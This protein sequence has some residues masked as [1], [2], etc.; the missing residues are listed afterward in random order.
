M[1]NYVGVKFLI[2]IS[3]MVLVMFILAFSLINKS[4]ENKKY[5]HYL[6]SHL[7]MNIS[8][9]VTRV[10]NSD[11]SLNEAITNRSISV[12]KLSFLSANLL[13]ISH[14]INTLNKLAKVVK[15]EDP[16]HL[17]N[18]AAVDH[19][20]YINSQ[21]LHLPIYE[22]N[23]QQNDKLLKLNDDNIEKLKQIQEDVSS[24]KQVIYKALEISEAPL[25]EEYIQKHSSDFIVKK[26]WIRLYREL[27]NLSYS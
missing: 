15:D 20:M 9:L 22:L 10:S 3:V 11:R 26:D 5:Q 19:H 4:N 16:N 25:S 8:D 12:Y 14:E 2:V 6:S 13:E 24:W 17:I 27:Q 23:L 7:L 21:I 1:K 18:A